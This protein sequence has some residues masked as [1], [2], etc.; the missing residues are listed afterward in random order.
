LWFAYTLLVFSVTQWPWSLAYGTVFTQGTDLPW[1]PQAVFSFERTR[2][3]FYDKE[4][5]VE[6][7]WLKPRKTLLTTA[8]EMVWLAEG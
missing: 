6:M 2:E 3:L 4:E 8:I 1:N 5:K 7:H